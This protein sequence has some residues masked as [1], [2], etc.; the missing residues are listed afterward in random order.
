MRLLSLAPPFCGSLHA[1]GGR[2]GG[3]EA[4]KE[5]GKEGWREGDAGGAGG[6]GHTC[7]RGGRGEEEEAPG[8]PSR[9]PRRQLQDRC[10]HSWRRHPAP[11]PQPHRPSP[12]KRRPRRGR[13]AHSWTD[14]PPPQLEAELPPPGRCAAGGGSSPGAW[15]GCGGPQARSRLA[16][17]L[18]TQGHW[19]GRVSSPVGTRL[20]AAGAA[21][22][23][24]LGF[25]T[26]GRF[27]APGWQQVW[28]PQ[29][30]ACPY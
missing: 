30:K 29:H 3:R 24:R 17:G 14:P 2:A 16:E 10:G 1:G 27:A 21:A 18:D 22:K 28:Q 25:P 12:G 26:H 6:E 19:Q 23:A 7:R 20:E 9:G 13:C 15:G 8:V 11:R 4:G 5:A